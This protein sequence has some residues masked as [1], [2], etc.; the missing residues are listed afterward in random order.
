MNPTTAQSITITDIELRT[1]S[2]SNPRF[3][4]PRQYYIKFSLGNTLRTTKKMKQNKNGILWNEE[5]SFRGDDASVLVA[6]VYRT[7][8][9]PGQQDEAVA[10]LTYTIGEI[11]SKLKNKVFEEPLL[12]DP[13]KTAI[14]SRPNFTLKFTFTSVPCQPLEAD[15]RQV[16]D[17]VDTA[18]QAVE[19]MR[20]TPVVDHLSSAVDTVT[21]VV[22]S[23]QTFATTW[24]V[25]LKRIKL[26]DQIVTGIAEIHPYTSLAWSVISA[27][28]KVLVN[29]NDRDDQITRLAGT[30]SDVLAFVHDADPLKA[31][32]AHVEPLKLLTQQVMECAYFIRDYAEHKSFV[33]RLAKYTLSDINSK[34]TDY[35]RRLQE[36]RDAF[37]RGVGLQTGI[38]VVR[39]MNVIE[40]TVEDKDLDDMPY[41]K[42]ARHD[43]DKGCLTGTR[44]EVLRELREILSNPAEDAPRVCLLTGFAGS[45]KS[46]VAHSMA[47][48]FEGQ[49]RLVSSYCFARTDVA[50]RNPTNLFSTVARDLCDHNAEYKSALWKV[51]GESRSLRTSEVPTEQLERLIIEPSKHIQAIGPLVVV[52]DA[53]DECGDQASRQQLVLA[54]SRL[55]T[56]TSFPFNLRFLITT[57]P[58]SDI[59][60]KLPPGPRLVHKQMSNISEQMVDEDIEKFIRHSLD[61]WSSELDL[62]NQDWCRLLV[63]HSQHLFQWAATACKF[64]QGFGSIGLGRSARLGL[65]LKTRRTEAGYPLDELYKTVLLQLFKSAPEQDRF[66]EVMGVLLALKEPLPLP[67]LSDLLHGHLKI[68]MDILED[69]PIDVP[70]D[71]RAMVSSLASLLDGACDDRKPVRPLHASFYDFLR[72]GK[73]S[74]AFHIPFLPQHSLTLGQASLVCMCRM[75]KF[76]ICGLADSRI[77]NDK[78]SGLSSCVDEAIPPHLSYSC[79]YWMDHLQHTICSSDL[80]SEITLFFKRFFPYWL[81]VISLLSLSSASPISSALQACIALQ[82][83]AQPKDSEICTLAS[84]GSRFIQVFS[85]LLRQCTPHLYLMLQSGLDI[86]P[87]GQQMFIPCMDIVVL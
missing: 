54:I 75:L 51:V 71:V 45:G 4:L 50:R 36:L 60:A 49:K 72:D 21:Q 27:A 42:G 15:E 57:R 6:K 3:A 35:Q 73:R 61:E 74:S 66:R 44:D 64:I 58:E 86:Q 78:V 63:H 11:I 10:S 9:M 7:H 13:S 22:N 18:K 33:T 20:P 31:D 41:A 82:H 81:E 83:W 46:A 70:V 14:S 16:A 1:A 8:R 2:G 76:N 29:Q 56:E 24:D 37:L 26:F 62:S 85:P 67:C 47:R 38:T 52:I 40:H 65:L 79:L 55:A 59:L 5:I 68:T 53:L 87:I 30:M 28:H 17:A 69:I 25:L 77:L 48:W 23:A 43:Q 32:R 12:M 84:E 19:A 34:I 80:N 39:M